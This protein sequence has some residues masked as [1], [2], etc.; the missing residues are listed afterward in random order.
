MVGGKLREE[1]F[2]NGKFEIWAKEGLLSGRVIS[3]PDQTVERETTAEP[4]R[5]SLSSA[6]EQEG[7]EA[8]ARAA[9][10]N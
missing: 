2:G 5:Q 4:S 1:L 3:F 7:D 9:Q 8:E 6:G 10:P